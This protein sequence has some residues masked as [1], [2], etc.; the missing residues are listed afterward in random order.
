MSIVEF[1]IRQK[2]QGMH[3]L[4]GKRVLVTGSTAGIGA[5]VAEGFVRWGAQV[6]LHG[7]VA[8]PLTDRI[9]AAGGTVHFVAGDLSVPDAAAAVVAAAVRAM[10]GLDV[11]VNNAG[12]IPV[13]A[14][15]TD[16][17]DARFDGII[18]LN[19]RPVFAA[20]AAA[21]PH[22]K[23]AGGGAIINTGSVSGRTGGPGGSAIYAAAKAAVHSFTRTAA[24]ELAP[25]GIRVNC[26]VPGVI[27]TAFH[28][29][30]P[31]EMKEA[32]S[33]T[34][35]LGRLGRAEDCVGAFLFLAS[36]EMSGYVTGQLIDVNGGIHMA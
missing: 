17:D 23:A 9:R 33:R 18:G 7:R 22:L 35:P 6:C 29:S 10:G 24:R 16:H 19:L 25:D 12:G 5:A 34:V 3:D 11:L 2:G 21:H 26:V 31:P 36:P 14:G 27:D 8:S 32:V 20:T 15:C 1:S 30:T 13:R 4:A 28:V